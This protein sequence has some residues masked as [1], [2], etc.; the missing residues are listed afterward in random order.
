MPNHTIF[1][2]QNANVM[3]CESN[4][5]ATMSVAV[6]SNQS[7]VPNSIHVHGP[8]LFTGVRLDAFAVLCGVGD[9]E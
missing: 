3:R 4:H 9:G 7:G 8:W 5:F 6:Y 1:R 2:L